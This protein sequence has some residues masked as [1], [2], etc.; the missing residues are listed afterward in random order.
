M[1][2][3]SLIKIVLMLSTFLSKQ[4]LLKAPIL[5]PPNWKKPFDLLCE[6][7]H[8]SVGAT[9]C[10]QYGDGINMIHDS[11][12]LNDAQ[13]NCPLIEKEFFT[14]VFACEKFRSYISDS[15]V[16]VYTDC[17][18]LKEILERTDVNSR[19]IR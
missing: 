10:Q 18:G 5:Q 6:L 4:A 14:V 2:G 3:L 7:S 1:F 11:R 13:I 9:L 16:R 19:M 8:E 12:T 15:K 17:L